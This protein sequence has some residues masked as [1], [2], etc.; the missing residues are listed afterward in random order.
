MSGR[1]LTG[2]AAGAWLG[3]LLGVAVMLF[4]AV[5]I[6]SGTPGLKSLS[7]VAASLVCYAVA[8]A[9]LTW[10]PGIRRYPGRQ[11]AGYTLA[12]LVVVPVIALYVGSPAMAALLLVPTAHAALRHRGRHA[13][14][15][16]VASAALWITLR[17]AGLPVEPTRV[18]LSG[19]E[20]LPV[21]LLL[22]M[23][24]GLAGELDASRTQLI[25]RADRDE[26]TGLLNMAAFSR[27]ADAEHAR[28]AAADDHYT[29]LMVDIDRLQ[30]FNDR[31]GHQQGN[32]VLTA[33]ADAL[34]RSTRSRDWVARYGGD[35]FVVLLPGSDDAVA[36]AVSNRIAQNVYNITLS[37]DRSMQR[38]SVSL[39]RAVYPDSGT[40]VQALLNFANRAMHRD[41]AFRQRVAAGRSAPGARQRQT[42]LPAIDRTESS[43]KE[44]S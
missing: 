22:W 5:A 28:A 40:T 30:V 37:F 34:R 25:E 10:L 43:C 29:L 41:K 21:G 1:P 33:V 16:A 31:F 24:R 9:L 23:L 26:L 6:V 32:R 4:A 27:L 19:M 8:I 3:L 17:N 35:E 14:L 12:M 13:L 38:V 44:P 15:I 42:D 2:A 18:L 39:G 20:L 11:S 36:E 7:V